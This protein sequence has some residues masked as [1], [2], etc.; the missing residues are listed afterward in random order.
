M[1]SAFNVLGGFSCFAGKIGR[2][3]ASDSV[4]IEDDATRTLGGKRYFDDEGVAVRKTV[5]VSRGVLKGFL[6]NTSTA[7]K[8]RKR[9][10]G[11]AGLVSPGAFSLSMN[12]GSE[13]HEKMIE[14]LR[15]GLYINNVWY[16]RYQ[17]RKIGNFS[18]I[19]RDAILRVRKGEIVGS[20]RDIRITENLIKL[21][22]KVDSVS[23][24]RE[25]INWWLESYTPSTVP[26]LLVRNLNITRSA[27]TN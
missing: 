25:H 27:D 21:L 20:V 18:T 3:V 2:K 1:S 8:F 4:T 13:S 17:N 24:E 9:T 14:E 12:G 19:P 15:D 7:R 23:K 16:T 5:L 11:N 26:Y 10:T 22:Q 6:H